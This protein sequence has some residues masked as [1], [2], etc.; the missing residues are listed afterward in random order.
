MNILL[1]AGIAVATFFFMEFVAWGT[2]KYV[3]HGW[4]W[5][6]HRDHHQKEPGFFEKNDLFFMVFAIPS[7]ACF[8]VGSLFTIWW[9]MAIGL[10][11]LLYGICYFL[12]HDVFIHRR[13]NWFKGS[14]SSYLQALRD[15][16]RRHHANIH[17]EGGTCFGMLIVPFKYHEERR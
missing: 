12:V 17:K 6:W 11:I 7:M 4:L 14:K 9:T 1:F 5:S 2:H 15:A 16:H 3:M 13:F 8:V 10:G